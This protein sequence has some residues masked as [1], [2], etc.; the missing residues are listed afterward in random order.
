MAKVQRVSLEL[1]FVL[2]LA[3]S[4]YVLELNRGEALELHVANGL[5]KLIRWQRGRNGELTKV[6]NFSR[7]EHEQNWIR[8]IRH[9]LGHHEP[10]SPVRCRTVISINEPAANFVSIEQWANT[11]YDQERLDAIILGV[12]RLIDAYRWAGLRKQS[13]LD[14]A[15]KFKVAKVHRIGP[16]HFLEL[17]VELFNNAVDAGNYLYQFSIFRE[18]D[19]DE[20]NCAPEITYDTSLTTSLR[21]LLKRELPNPTRLEMDAFSSL[22][23]HDPL[24]AAFLY[25]ALTDIEL[26]RAYVK[27]GGTDEK[28]QFPVKAKY[29]LAM[30][31]SKDEQHNHAM[32][33]VFD[34]A[35]AA[36]TK[37]RNK[38]VHGGWVPTLDS[39]WDDFI[40][41]TELISFL[42]TSDTK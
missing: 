31:R 36:H 27:C 20:Y 7:P 22:I 29:I 8:R 18:I 30:K 33:G 21:K 35:I 14:K 13:G 25:W 23:A 42:K 34:K 24:Q 16:P 10:I 32:K 17:V 26:N 40:L 11:R 41:C 37:H 3:D 6:V 2:A 15:T 1:P 28:K 12:N 5:S 9:E 38:M 4:D 19:E 39:A